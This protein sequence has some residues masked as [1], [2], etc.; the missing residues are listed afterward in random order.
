VACGPFLGAAVRNERLPPRVR[1]LPLRYAAVRFFFER[2]CRHLATINVSCCFFSWNK[3]L[4]TF[5]LLA[6]HYY[7]NVVVPLGMNVLVTVVRF[8]A[9]HSRAAQTT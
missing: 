7:W 5:R 2:A 3:H 8:A 6:V 4:R 1:A 9:M